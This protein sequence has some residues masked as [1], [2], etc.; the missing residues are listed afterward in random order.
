MTRYL[1]F[2]TVVIAGLAAC[3]KTKTASSSKP[4][5]NI[6]ACSLITNDEVAK[7]EGSP[8]TQ[9]KPSESSDESFRF[10]QCFYTTQV[11]SKSVSLA[12]TQRNLT[13]DKAK[14]PKT[15]WKETFGR[16][17][18]RLKE[19]EGDEEKRKSL[20]EKGEEGA[21]APKKMEGLGD[22][23]WWTANRIGG[24]IYALK[25]N[26]FIRIS[27]GGPDSEESKKERSKALAQKALSRL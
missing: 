27:V 26:V 11:F 6:T 13:S 10:S 25:N 1:L 20:E 5:A 21:V 24:A 3:Q 19:A 23:A 8:V 16:Y 7:I 12:V 15:F 14:D 22:D 2:G 17:E 18:G 4:E 9:V